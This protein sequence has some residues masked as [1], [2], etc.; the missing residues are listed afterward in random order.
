VLPQLY[1]VERGHGPALE[2]LLPW[3]SWFE[4]LM[5]KDFLMFT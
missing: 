5:I 2:L 1:L 4:K 3:N